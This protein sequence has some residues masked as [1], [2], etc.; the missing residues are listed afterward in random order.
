MVADSI[1]VEHED[2]DTAAEIAALGKA[3]NAGA[4]ASFVGYVR[5][6]DG[7]KSLTLEHYPGMTEREIAKHVADARKRWPLLAV[8]IVHRIGKLKVGEQIV[9]VGAAAEHRQAAFDAV[10]YLMD[11][12]KSRAPFWKQEEREGENRWVE[13]KA[14]DKNLLN[15][16][17]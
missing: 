10:Q 11:Y 9:F 13:A 8:R 7:V 4:V 5:G 15:R 6:E 14:S 3:A 12:L 2:F 1:R 17:R 16:W